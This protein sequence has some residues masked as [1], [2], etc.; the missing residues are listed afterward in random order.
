MAR[1]HHN[2]DHDY[3]DRKIDR[4]TTNMFGIPLTLCDTATVKRCAHCNHELSKD[5]NIPYPKRLIAAAALYRCTLPTRLN[6]KEMK[7]VRKAINISAKDWAVRVSTDPS[8]LSRWESDSQAMSAAAEKLL[9]LTAIVELIEEAPAIDV[10][11]KE[12]SELKLE[13]FAQQD[14]FMEL[15]FVLSKYRK[16]EPE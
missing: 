15:Q 4:H 9:R 8:T 6:G 11:P 10:N 16:E 1:S 14:K 3:I 7:F 2:C 13:G 5:V 12:I